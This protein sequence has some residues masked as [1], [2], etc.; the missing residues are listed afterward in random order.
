MFLLVVLATVPV[1][2]YSQFNWATPIVTFVLSVAML[3]IDTCSIEC[4]RPFKRVPT[5]NHI[6]VESLAIGIS[7][8]VVEIVQS[9]A[10]QLER[11]EAVND[12]LHEID[13]EDNTYFGHDN[14]TGQQ[15]RTVKKSSF[16]IAFPHIGAGGQTICENDENDA[17][18][19]V[20]LHGEYT[21][22]HV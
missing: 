22:S 4:E 18:S 7:K 17:R 15:I 14:P 6:D 9:A 8:D 3:G 20:G 16:A 2:F 13:E 19:S 1:V 5:M 12:A 21:A 10:I 11:E